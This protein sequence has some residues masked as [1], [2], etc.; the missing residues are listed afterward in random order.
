MRTQPV[1]P[2]SDSE[3]RWLAGELVTFL[4]WLVVLLATAEQRLVGVPAVFLTG[5][6]SV[7]A[8]AVMLLGLRRRD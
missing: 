5:A 8:Y 4:V 3:F 6:V 1:S 2:H 7:V